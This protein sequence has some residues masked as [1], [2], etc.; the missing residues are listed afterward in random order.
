MRRPKTTR[1]VM[2]D[3]QAYERKPD[4]TLVPLK[5]HTDWKRVD[6]MTDEEIGAIAANDPESRPLTDDEWAKIKLVDPF[7]EP[8]T[9]RLDRD[10]VAWF[11]SKG[12]GYQTRINAVLRRYVD[13]QR[14][15]G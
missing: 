15:A 2:V 5:D 10:L 8:V 3:G 11:R 6:A 13:A 7:K 14:K 9:I 4:G 12:K 1:A